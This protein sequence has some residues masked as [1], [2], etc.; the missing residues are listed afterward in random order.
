MLVF[1]NYGWGR[2]VKKFY[3]WNWCCGLKIYFN[4]GI[5]KWFDDF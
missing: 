4:F 5:I 1:V 2:D 3:L